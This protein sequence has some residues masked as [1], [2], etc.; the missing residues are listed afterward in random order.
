MKNHF[1]L[2]F[3]QKKTYHAFPVAPRRESTNK[4]QSMVVIRLS[5]RGRKHIAHFAIHVADQRAK[6]KGRFIER[7]GFIDT[8][9]D[10]VAKVDMTRYLHWI[11]Q[12]AQPSDRVKNLVKKLQSQQAS[13]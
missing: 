6:D 10:G 8:A 5:R 1:P 13:Q 2:F 4:G 12:G 3:F 9:K 7:L 11:A